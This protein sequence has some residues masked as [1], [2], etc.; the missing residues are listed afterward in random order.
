MTERTVAQS[1]T[2]GW[3]DI[4][5]S[6]WNLGSSQ[7]TIRI[8][9][10][11]LRRLKERVPTPIDVE[12]VRVSGLT[13]AHGLR[14]RRALELKLYVHVLCDLRSQGW[15]LRCSRSR[16]LAMAPA[17]GLDAAS[18]KSRVR[19]AHEV[20]RDQQL[21]QPSVRRFVKDMERMRLHRGE[22]R[23][24]FSLMRDGVD[25]SRQ[26]A[27]VAAEEGP[28]AQGLLRRTVDPYVQ[29]AIAGKRCAF[30][31]LDL[32]DVWRY[33]RH[34]WTTTYQSTPGRKLFFL[35]RDKAAPCHP[36]IGIAALGSPIVQLT[37]RDQWIGWTSDVLLQRMAA[38]LPAKWT[39]WLDTSIQELVDAIYIADFIAEGHLR[40]VDLTSPTSEVMDRLRSLASTERAQHRLYPQR[41]QHKRGSG[42][43]SQWAREAR[44][45]LFRSKR[46]SGLAELLRARLELN[47]ATLSGLTPEKW[48][49]ALR[50]G[51]VRRAVTTIARHVKASHVGID[52]M[53]ITVC[54]AVAPYNHVLGGKLVALMV[55]SPEVRREY[56]RRYS[57]APSI[58]ASSMAGRAIVRRPR[59]VLLGTTSL[60][61]IAPS[62][63]NRLRMSL[64]PGGGEL[65]YE[66]L[67]RTVGY[68]SYHF[69]Q[70]TVEAVELLLARLESGRPVNSI[71][72]EGVNPK[73]RKVRAALDALG[74]PANLLLQHGSPRLVY[75]VVLARNFREILLGVESRPHYLLPNGRR[76]T[77]MIVDH[78]RDRWLAGR[79]HNEAVLDAVAE[80]T[81]TSPVRHGARVALPV[82]ES[83]SSGAEDRE[84]DQFWAHTDE[85]DI[86][87]EHTAEQSTEPYS[88]RPRSRRLA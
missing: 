43:R 68:G 63:Y 87:I 9:V 7:K 4:T 45:H 22:W 86:G 39:R 17:N 30:T 74:L 85:E 8:V 24:I 6:I 61:S 78:W 60:Y 80:H 88:R 18:E 11:A 32:L 36:V 65:I 14:S 15:H 52:V 57:K 41:E 10:S 20:D 66:P 51:N 42:S 64:G 54:G 16:V 71:F 27:A 40:R 79:I 33:F 2:A 77:Q 12:S 58:I 25:L 34:T 29:P 75:G 59:L 1:T 35:I 23:S 26:L 37:V 46:A 13:A 67:G 48:S 3:I 5:P 82:T 53:D 83:V 47:E 21:R 56:Q 73:L 28:L 62:Q 19:A 49:E 50:S 55:V 81:L 70:G 38:E 69:S 31:G 84:S 72:G 76:A 44:T